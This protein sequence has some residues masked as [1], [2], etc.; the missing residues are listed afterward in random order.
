M[1]TP[2]QRGGKRTVTS[3]AAALKHWRVFSG[4]SEDGEEEMEEDTVP[5]GS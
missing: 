3:A 1:I 2:L 5:N 4:P